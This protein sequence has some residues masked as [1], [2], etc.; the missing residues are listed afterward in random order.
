M[1][2]S[3]NSKRDTDSF[4][5]RSN[6]S[7]NRSSTS[8]KM[9]RIK[10]QTARKSIPKKVITNLRTNSFSQAGRSLAQTSSFFLTCSQTKS[11]CKRSP[12]RR[13]RET[14]RPQ[15]RRTRKRSTRGQSS[16]QSSNLSSNLKSFLK[17]NPSL[18]GSSEGELLPKRLL[19]S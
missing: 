4:P 6:R 5:K 15:K 13:R 18:R 8:A 19:K 3:L 10:I 2:I 14:T 1:L 16:N 11:A 12:Y 17:P 9:L 7:R